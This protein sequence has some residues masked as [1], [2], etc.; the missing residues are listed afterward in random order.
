MPT[1]QTKE[2]LGRFLEFVTNLGKF[3]PNLS[4][5]DAPFRDLLKTDVVFDWQPAHEEAFNKLKD[6]CCSHP[7]LKY[8]DVNKQ[9]KIQCD[10]SHHGLGAVLIQDGHP[11]AYSSQSLT[12]FKLKNTM[13]KSRNRCFPSFTRAL[14]STA[15]SSEKKLQCT[16]TTNPLN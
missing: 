12:K 2:D 6:Q 8:F 4:E 7:V 9:V 13:H 10:S 3:I 11:V 5:I 15:I 1:P 16:M 14:N